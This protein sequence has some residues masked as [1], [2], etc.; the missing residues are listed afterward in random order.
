M[1]EPGLEN[2][3]IA[4]WCAP[5]NG[6][7]A[8]KIATNT[9]DANG[10]YIFYGVYPG[11]CFIEVETAGYVYSPIVTGGN[12]VGRDGRSTIVEVK[13]KDVITSLKGGLYRPFEELCH[14]D[15]DID[16]KECGWGVWNR[17]TCQVSCAH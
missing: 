15:C 12:Q 11:Q 10:Q 4:L 8:V 5:K 3:I 6:Q 17:C 13:S 7:P 9:T 2:I 16:V 1:G 14:E